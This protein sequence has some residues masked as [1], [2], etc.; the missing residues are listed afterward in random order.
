MEEALKQLRKFISAV[1][2]FEDNEWN[3]FAAIWKPFEAKRKTLL[4]KTGET[5][6]LFIFCT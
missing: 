1:Q 3:D 4:T 6:R 2:P 5:E